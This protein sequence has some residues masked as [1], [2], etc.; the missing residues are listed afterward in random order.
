MALPTTTKALVL[1]RDTAEQQDEARLVE[2]PIPSLKSGEV[3][4]KIGAA[5]L[6]HRDVG[7][8]PIFQPT[9]EEL[10]VQIKN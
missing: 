3:L 7:V 8:Y 6:N 9:V 10:N 1:H 5:G 4:V 2:R